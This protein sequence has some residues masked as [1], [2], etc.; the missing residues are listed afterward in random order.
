MKRSDKL[1]AGKFA[2]DSA[3]VRRL[4]RAQFPALAELAIEPLDEDGW[5]NWTFRLG[6][7]LKVRLPTDAAY[8]G[9]AAK[10]FEWLPRLAPHLPLAVPKPVALGTADAA[11]PW[12][13]SIYEW[14]P[15]R[16]LRYEANLDLVSFAEDLAGFLKA[17]QAIDNAGGPPPGAHN[18]HRGGDPC[19]IY[20]AQARVALTTVAD[21]IDVGG[22][23]AVLDRAAAAPFEGRPV[24]LHGDIAVGNLLMRDGQLSA[25]ID[26]GSSA[27]GDPACDLV[28]SWLFLD[29]EARARFRD[30]MALDPGCWARARAW[31]L[32]KAAIVLAA[33]SPIHPDERPPLAVI[34][35][36]VREHREN[37]G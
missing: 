31:A 29:G 28:I 21:R 37:S 33:G 18:F 27:I 15:G 35:T 14:I 11:Y 16:P 17:L 9:Q 26:F 20:G 23:M 7:Y 36:V 30:A 6:P 13:W 4:L 22:A 19:Q 3:L 5:D 32:W 2:V 25:V 12:P 1:D 34:E 8:A 24:W 10:E